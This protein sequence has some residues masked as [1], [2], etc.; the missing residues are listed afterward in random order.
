MHS[1]KHERA[2]QAHVTRPLSRFPTAQRAWYKWL[3][4]ATLEGHRPILPAPP[5]PGEPFNAAGF[6]SGVRDIV[7]GALGAEPDERPSFDA[8]VEALRLVSS[9]VCPLVCLF[10]CYISSHHA[11]YQLRLHYSS[12]IRELRMPRLPSSFS[13]LL[14]SLRTPARLL[15]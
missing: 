15:W 9:Q 7:L 14:A 4:R 3:R 12:R 2:V 11:R 5:T 6:P 10:V 1:N 8:I 13:C